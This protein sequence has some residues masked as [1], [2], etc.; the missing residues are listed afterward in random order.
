M[1]VGMVLLLRLA[2]IRIYL[3]SNAILCLYMKCGIIEDVFQV[4][5]LRFFLQSD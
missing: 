5:L 4:K 3:C 2:S 1:D